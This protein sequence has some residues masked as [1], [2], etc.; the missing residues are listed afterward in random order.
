MPDLV[1]QKN[2]Y[3]VL[4]VDCDADGERIRQ[5]YRRLMQQLRQHP[6]LGGD[7][8][9]AALI[10]KAYAALGNPARRAEYDARL[11]ILH[12]VAR[13]IV[14]EPSD[15]PAFRNIDPQQACPFCRVAHDRGETKDVDAA[16]GNCGSPLSTADNVRIEPSDQRAVERLC[17]RLDVA[18]FTHWHQSKGFRGQTEDISLNGLRLVTR[19]DIRTGQHIRIVSDLVEAVG[20]VTNCVPKHGIWRTEYVAGVSFVTL[21]FMRSV[22]AFLS[23]RA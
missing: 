1:D 5:G 22:G 15:A 10:N 8:A 13:G 17:R 14:Q 21:R 16:C 2:F 23:Q 19:T 11:K 12:H 20:L 6:D 18:F 7:T 3:E 9:T 4:Q